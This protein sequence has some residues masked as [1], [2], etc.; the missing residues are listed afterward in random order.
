MKHSLSLTFLFS[1]FVLAGPALAQVPYGSLVVSESGGADGFV[2][3]DPATGY[4]TPIEEP[5][6]NFLGGAL[7][8]S[9]DAATG[10]SL[11]TSAGFSIGGPPLLEV[12]LDANFY[13]VNAVNGQALPLF[14]AL[15]RAHSVPGRILVTISTVQSG[16]W[17][18]PTTTG[19]AQQLLSAANLRD[20][21]VIGNVAYAC[22]YA[23]SSNVSAIWTIDLGTGVLTTL[24]ASYPQLR[25]IC[26]V[27]GVLF[28]GRADGEISVVDIG[29]GAMSPF[30]VT[31]L[32][33]IEAMA[34][35]SAG[36][37]YFA[38]AGNE[39]YDT[40]NLAAPVYVSPNTITDIDVAVTDQP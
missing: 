27:N 30:L 15:E 28:A 29:T 17:S 7:T 35:A 36:A 4:V 10:N 12:P 9:I 13:D 16:V 22:T 32:G 39:V 5:N 38:T 14:G 3:V 19:T 8:V 26:A 31:G 20:V 34:A 25:S 11:I 18:L 40:S 24:G 2:I 1:S 23:S 37:I 33:S 6:G 21:A